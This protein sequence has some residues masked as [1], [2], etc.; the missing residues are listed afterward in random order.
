[1]SES[2]G[3]GSETE[4]SRRRPKKKQCL[5]K[6]LRKTKMCLHFE[7]GE[8]S[9]GKECS[10][11]HDKAELQDAP[12]LRKTRLCQAFAQGVCNDRNCSFAH[13][14][15]ELR[16]TDLFFKKTLCMWNEKGKCRAG[17]TCRFAHGST[18][19][20]SQDAAEASAAAVDQALPSVGSAGHPTGCNAPCKYFWKAR[21]CKDGAKC[22]RCHLCRWS[23]NAT[24][25][26]KTGNVGEGDSRKRKR[27]AGADN[28]AQR[29]EKRP[30]L[31]Q[32]RPVWVE[33]VETPQ[34]NEHG[35][36]SPSWLRSDTRSAAEAKGQKWTTAYAAL[37]PPLQMAAPAYPRYA[38]PPPS[39]GCAHGNGYGYGHA[40]G[41]SVPLARAM[42]PL[43]PPHHGHNRQLQLACPAHTLQVVPAL[44][45]LGGVGQSSK[46]GRSVV[47]Q[48]QA[49]RQEGSQR[50]H[51]RMASI[52]RR[53]ILLSLY[54]LCAFDDC[55]WWLTWF[56]G[57]R[58]K[59]IQL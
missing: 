43:P 35:N 30:A 55:G 34:L 40:Y 19:L 51:S 2:A 26:N 59:K 52:H 38:A 6:Q 33:E 47:W 16:S 27:A 29:P 45:H 24:A 18:E 48:P 57:L 20:R 9:F 39:H 32:R 42:L 23:R 7:R 25:G 5:V 41:Y 49:L 13:D 58:R 28:G 1:M 54:R 15:A 44:C 8:C 53:R 56:A 36:S 11:A 17:A 12:D 3:S 21:G 50:C 46:T 31:E 22:D 4:K 37:L 10:F 14:E